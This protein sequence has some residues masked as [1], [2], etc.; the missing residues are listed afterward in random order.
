MLN[1]DSH[2]HLRVGFFV[3]GDR[4]LYLIGAIVVALIILRLAGFL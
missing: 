2:A 4:V 3:S 1:G